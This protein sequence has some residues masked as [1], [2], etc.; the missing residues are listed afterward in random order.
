M[1]KSVLLTDQELK[2]LLNIIE[3]H[4]YI[5]DHNATNIHLIKRR[6]I[7]LINAKKQT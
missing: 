1:Y 7:N 5:K 2:L 4:K 3:S 6:I